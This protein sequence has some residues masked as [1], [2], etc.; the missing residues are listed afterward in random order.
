MRALARYMPYLPGAK[1][2]IKIRTLPDAE[3]YEDHRK[4]FGKPEKG[5]IS[6][7]IG[8]LGFFPGVARRHIDPVLGAYWT[9]DSSMTTP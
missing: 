8:F 1:N 3:L 2:F 9:G 5:K 4:I 6:E 7:Q